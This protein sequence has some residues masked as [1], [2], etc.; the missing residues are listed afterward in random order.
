MIPPRSPS[1]TQTWEQTHTTESVLPIVCIR[2]L[3][4]HHYPGWWRRPRGN[5]PSRL[6]TGHD[7]SRKG[8]AGQGEARAESAAARRR[9]T[10][11][12]VHINIARHASDRHYGN[13]AHLVTGHGKWRTYFA[14]RFTYESPRTLTERNF[15]GFCTL[16]KA[17][18]YKH[19]LTDK[20]TNAACHKQTMDHMVSQPLA[21]SV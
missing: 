19:I 16:D 11:T 4:R 3:T 14:S 20:G 13:R 7:R 5:S 15:L 18:I 17:H 21:A 2:L 9:L 1:I 6:R 8:T 10:P 12:A